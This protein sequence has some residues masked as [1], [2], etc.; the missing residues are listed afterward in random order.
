MINVP[1][2]IDGHMVAVFA[3]RI[4]NEALPSPE[5]LAASQA[6]ATRELMTTRSPSRCSGP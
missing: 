3:L 4:A 6:L 1:M 5:D 2:V